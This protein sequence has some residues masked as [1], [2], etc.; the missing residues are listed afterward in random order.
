MKKNEANGICDIFN[1]YYSNEF[2][3]AI[4]SRK[5]KKWNIDLINFLLEIASNIFAQ[6][7]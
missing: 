1:A 2:K 5:R 6:V 3:S 4:L 7:L